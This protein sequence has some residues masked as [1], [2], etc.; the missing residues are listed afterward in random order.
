MQSN[1]IRSIKSS[2]FSSTAVLAVIF[3]GVLSF[4]FVKEW[5]NSLPQFGGDW[6][7]VFQ[8]HIQEENR[9]PQLWEHSENLGSSQAGR[10]ALGLL[11]LIQARIAD[12][13]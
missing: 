7:Y 12:A 9:F 1:L 6:H 11:D 4:V 13:T 3:L 8:E 2:V 5:I 10:I